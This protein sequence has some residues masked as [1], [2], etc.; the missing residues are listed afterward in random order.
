MKELVELMKKKAK[1]GQMSDREAEARLSVLDELKNMMHG[2]MARDLP[3]KKVSAH[4]EAD[5]PEELKEGLEKAGEV[6]DRIP[7]IEARLKKDPEEVQGEEASHNLEPDVNEEGDED[8]MDKAKAEML[9][10]FSK[11]E[12][13]EPAEEEE[14]EDESMEAE[15]KEP[16]HKKSLKKL[17]I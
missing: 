3:Q 1:D 13:E 16:A 10:K 4:V 15:A 8:M 14:G 17:R 7:A 11:E 9:A 5:S 6:A 2:H 12:S